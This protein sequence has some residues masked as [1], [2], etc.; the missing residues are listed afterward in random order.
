MA[1]TQILSTHDHGRSRVRCLRDI[2][3]STCCRA[4]PRGQL[5]AS[6]CS[7]SAAARAAAVRACT[8]RAVAARTRAPHAP[9]CACA[10]PAHTATWRGAA[11]A[12]RWPRAQAPHACDGLGPP[13]PSGVGAA[14]VCTGY[15]RQ[16][17][18]HW[19]CAATP[20]ALAVRVRDAR[21]GSARRPV[22]TVGVGNTVQSAVGRSDV[23]RWPIKPGVG[24]AA[25]GA[26]AGAMSM[27]GAPNKSYRNRNSLSRKERPTPTLPSESSRIVCLGCTATLPSGLR[28]A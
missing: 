1:F 7:Y 18:V 9:L 25:G 13:P 3:H 10:R 6:C 16:H 5:R 23:C 15:A 24:T 21:R 26:Y 19:L 17:R 27:C 20:C 2:W 28:C 4:G 14:A 22:C 8:F 12:C 11:D